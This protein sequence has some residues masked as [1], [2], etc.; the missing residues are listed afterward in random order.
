MSC[1][2]QLAV[3]YSTVMST[4]LIIIM[5]TDSSPGEVRVGREGCMAE[6]E[7]RKK[8]ESKVSEGRMEER[9]VREG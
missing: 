6:R 9:E 8:D 5:S 7:G 4:L 3:H 1:Y 2:G